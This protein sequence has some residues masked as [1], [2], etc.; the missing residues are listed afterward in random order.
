MSFLVVSYVFA[1]DVVF[2]VDVDFVRKDGTLVC[3]TLW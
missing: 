2:V 3:R 1:V